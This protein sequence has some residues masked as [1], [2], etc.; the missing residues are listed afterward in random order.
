MNLSFCKKIYILNIA[1]LLT[2]I[3]M[4]TACN[5]QKPEEKSVLTENAAVSDYLFEIGCQAVCGE[6]RLING[7]NY[8]FPK[9]L[10]L[11]LSRNKIED[12]NVINFLEHYF[13]DKL[14]IVQG[15]GFYIAETER[16][17]W[18][19]SLLIRL[20]EERIA[21]ELSE[22]E[23]GL[24]EG[25]E[26]GLEETE[27]V[28]EE[29]IIP[30]I[31]E[32][33]ASLEN[34]GEGRVMTDSA[35]HL[36]FLEYDKEIFMPQKTEDGLITVHASLKTVKRDFYDKL[37]RLVKSEIWNI[38]G[39]DSA[40]LKKTEILEYDEN[41]FKPVSKKIIEGGFVESVKYNAAGLVESSEKFAEVKGK[42]NILFRRNIVYDDEG[43]I[44]KN[45]TIDYN[46]KD[47]E[48]KQLDYSFSKKYVYSYNEGD[49]PPD[50]SYYENGVLKM[51]NKYSLE[52]G[53]Y[54]SQIFFDENTSVKTYYENNTRVKD[55][56][57][58]G[59]KVLREKVY[60]KQENQ[61][62]Q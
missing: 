19:E 47:K 3:L 56:Y 38:P 36:K 46:Y 53:T 14:G 32:I 54:T 49:I 12:G 39:A 51:K 50:F 45:E 44:L 58:I 6:S 40:E 52:K 21:Q 59:N 42:Q 11:I 13:P 7:K 60:E 17:E 35:S 33:E 25:F 61:Q 37:Y 26:E 8:P 30:T 15:S 9:A 34:S 43:K 31:D 20:E 62:N 10:S 28:E 5:K 22:M 2:G 16:A 27:P 23:E 18:V 29:V 41:G 1:V 48:Y 57:Y 24:E 55:V 4:L